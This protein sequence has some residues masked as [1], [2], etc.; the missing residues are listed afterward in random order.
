MK[1]IIVFFIV[2]VLVTIYSFLL[3]FYFGKKGYNYLKGPKA[4][5]VSEDGKRRFNTIMRF[6]TKGFGIILFVYVAIPLWLDIPNLL[7]KNYTII[8][9]EPSLV[10]GA[11]FGLWFVKQN[12]YIDGEEI[13]V[14]LY[15]EPIREERTYSIQLLPHSGFAVMVQ[16]IE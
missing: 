7:N 6:L 16:R 15:H 3:F 2:L 9:G 5:T 11:P 10:S 8:E 12:V 1:M 13:L 14:L 4:Y